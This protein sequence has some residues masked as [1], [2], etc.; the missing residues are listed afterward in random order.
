MNPVVSR[1]PQLF[2]RSLK[3]APPK[4]RT[5]AETGPGP[6]MVPRR[7]VAIRDPPGVFKLYLLTVIKHQEK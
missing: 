6:R 4:F 2:A 5:A 7:E 1:T 3:C